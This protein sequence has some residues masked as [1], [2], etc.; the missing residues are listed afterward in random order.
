ML[1]SEF[2]VSVIILES[3]PSGFSAP[4]PGARGARYTLAFRREGSFVLR[5]SRDSQAPV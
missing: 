1:P 3:F 2:G 4:E 5:V